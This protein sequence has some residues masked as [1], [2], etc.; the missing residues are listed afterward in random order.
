[1]IRC[2]V[3]KETLVR[4]IKQLMQFVHKGVTAFIFLALIRCKKIPGYELLHPFH[5]KIVLNS[6]IKL[7][8]SLFVS[9]PWS[10]IPAALPELSASG[11]EQQLQNS[12][13]RL[14]TIKNLLRFQLVSFPV[15]LQIL[16]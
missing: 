1:M 12:P 6:E 3:G 14:T 8:I 9:I 7:I 4:R 5:G 15:F 11:R 10:K 16:F 2:N 13:S